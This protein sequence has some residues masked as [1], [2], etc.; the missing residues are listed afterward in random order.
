MSANEPP[1]LS[2]A[3]APHQKMLSNPTHRAHHFWA[4]R[5]D[6]AFA[7]VSPMRWLLFAFPTGQLGLTLLRIRVIADNRM[8]DAHAN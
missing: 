3:A 7:M 1:R 2:A 6:G 8:L 5:K 4:E